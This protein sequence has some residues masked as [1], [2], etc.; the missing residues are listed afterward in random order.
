MSK[1]RE[2]PAFRP[3]SLSLY[4]SSFSRSIFFLFLFSYSLHFLHSLN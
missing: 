3:L 4:D 2:C 1:E